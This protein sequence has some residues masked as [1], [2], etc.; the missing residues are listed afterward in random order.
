[1]PQLGSYIRNLRE[2]KGMSTYQAGQAANCSPT[3]FSLV[4]RGKRG[5]SIPML[6]QIISALDGDMR[7]ALILLAR[8]AGVPAEALAEAGAK[9]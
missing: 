5:V 2:C 7:R 1:M 9:A 4:E 6:W 8:D 3:V